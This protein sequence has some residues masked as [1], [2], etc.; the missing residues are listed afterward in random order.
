MAQE[1]NHPPMLA[2][3]RKYALQFPQVERGGGGNLMDQVISSATNLQSVW[4]KLASRPSVS[5][6][7]AEC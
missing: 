5:V 6:L 2:L 4:Q 3:L 7:P 1:C